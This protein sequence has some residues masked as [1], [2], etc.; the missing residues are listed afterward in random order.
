ML[1]SATSKVTAYL[2]MSTEY[3]RSPATSAGDS[4]L[5]AVPNDFFSLFHCYAML[6]DVVN[7]TL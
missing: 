3:C 6:G 2:W 5:I 1:S 7:V 4:R